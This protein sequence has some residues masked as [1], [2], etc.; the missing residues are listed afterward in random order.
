V[1]DAYLV[2]NQYQPYIEASPN[3]WRRLDLVHAAGS[4]Y[5]LELELRTDWGSGKGTLAGQCET[6]LIALDGIYLPAPRPFTFLPLL[7]GQRASIL[8]SCAKTGIVYLVSHPD[9]TLRPAESFAIDDLRYLQNLVTIVVTGEE[10][11]GPVG[12]LPDLSLIPRYTTNV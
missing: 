12:P 1:P 4:H 8:F 6:H 5:R 10:T 11:T 9:P 3:T 2:N 7:P